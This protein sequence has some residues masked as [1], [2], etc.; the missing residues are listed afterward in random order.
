MRKVLIGLFALLSL[1]VLAV[2]FGPGLIDWNRYKDDIAR[3]LA[4][5][6][7]YRVEIAGDLDLAVLPT[8]RFSAGRVSVSTGPAGAPPLAR[9]AALQARLKVAP[10]LRGRIEVASIALIEPVV[11]LVRLADGRGNWAAA[12]PSGEQGA[13]R[14]PDAVGIA[15][16]RIENGSVSYRDAA[17]NRTERVDRLS[18]ELSAQSLAGPFRG[19]GSLALKG[20]PLSFEAAVGRMEPDRPTAVTL[21]L[22]LKGTGAEAELT[23]VVADLGR[24]PRLT[25]QVKLH[26]DD[27]AKTV[28]ALPGAPDAAWPAQDFSAEAKLAVSAQEAA[29]NELSIRLGEASATGAVSLALGDVTRADVALRV[30]HLD[31]DKLLAAL[32]RSGARAPAPAGGAP[33]RFA[34]PRGVAGSIDLALDAA[35]WNG[36]QLRSVKL[37]A[38][39]A[40]GVLKLTDASAQLPGGA[41]ATLSGKLA[42]RDGR[43]SYDGEVALRADDLRTLLTWL[44]ADVSAVP[45]DRLRAFAFSARV[46]GDPE[47]LQLRNATLRLDTSKIG[48]GV[49]VALRPRPAFGARL[50]IDHLNLDGYMPPPA[51]GAAR[52]AAPGAPLALLQRFDANLALRIGSLTLRQVSVREVVVDGTLQSGTLTLRK[53]ALQGPAGSKLAVQGTVTGFDASPSYDGSFSAE[54]RDLPALLGLGGIEAGA[55]AARLGGVSLHGKGA[56]RAARV[57]FDTTLEAAGGTLG[58]S[59]QLGGLGATPQ[60]ALDL[61]LRHPEASAL[62]RLFDLGLDTRRRL[63]P[64]TLTSKVSGGLDKASLQA[65]LALSGGTA[66][67]SGSLADI[68]AKPAYDLTLDIAHPDLAA[69]AAALAGP[70]SAAPHGKLTATARIV[71]DPALV[72]FDRVSVNAAGTALGGSGSLALSG[73]RP[74]LTAKLTGEDIALETLLAPAAAS[75]SPASS[76]PPRRPP[77]TREPI[78]FGG[79][80]ALDANVSM[81]AKSLAWNEYRLDRPDLAVTLDDGALSLDRLTGQLF[82]GAF[83]AKGRLASAAQPARLSVSFSVRDADLREALFRSQGIDLLSGRLTATAALTGQGR[84]AYDIV[85]ALGGDGRFE[86]RDG[87][88]EGFDLPAVSARLE[89][90]DRTANLVALLGTALGGGRTPF[91]SLSGTA[92]VSNGVVRT[93]DT[94]LVSKAA[95]ADAK[96]EIDLPRWLI[97][98]TATVHMTEHADAP[99]FGVRLTGPL[100]APNRSLAT[101]SLQTYLLRRGVGRL[102]EG[103]VPRGKAAPST[104]GQPQAPSQQ[105]RQPSNPADIIRDLLQGLPQPR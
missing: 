9:V 54:T 42:E 36:R 55:W 7:G 20:V 88:L 29:L 22:G 53:A 98:M 40:D 1:A 63:G 87:V 21:V 70:Q 83:E 5:A 37:A 16:L 23:G 45:R 10:L 8:P 47:Q 52:P 72:R 18:A 56:V 101:D 15:S 102:L 92:R 85:A 32:G 104:G 2:L 28:A 68:V 81:T 96:G 25:G 39:L 61:T 31:V 33:A 43:P 79:L 66:T 86:V 80:R 89:H 64:V 30:G 69:L 6:T 105:Q 76:A 46:L 84:S 17:T 73:A 103:V 60:G 71:G 26:G 51:A 48:G 12:A 99:P 58:L 38:S 62:A 34:L 59:G 50:D 91:S 11:S 4:A 24:T 75:A 94:T 3:E 78:D 13:S 67:L 14:N 41:E 49:T 44:G 95:R 90:L 77:F 74:R 27:L 57:S 19:A 100:D 65:T 97:D 35:T 82:G 93:D